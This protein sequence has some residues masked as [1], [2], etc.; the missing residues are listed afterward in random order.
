MGACAS[1]P[2]R[3]G[4]ASSS[5]EGGGEGP[6]T[7]P[8]RFGREGTSAIGRRDPSRVVA[9]SAGPEAAP[10][11]RPSRAGLAAELHARQMEYDAALARLTL[12]SAATKS[13]AAEFRRRSLSSGG[14]TTVL[15]QHTHMHR[16]GRSGSVP[17]AW[18]GGGDDG[19]GV[20]G[21][22]D[23]KE[24]NDR[25]V[26]A[27]SEGAGRSGKRDVCD[28]CCSSIFEGSPFAARGTIFAPKRGSTTTVVLACG[29]SYHDECF[30]RLV[31][32]PGPDP[33]C[34][35]CRPTEGH[36]HAHTIAV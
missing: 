31:P 23:E 9:G 14:L 22:E 25:G 18:V 27:S 13:P 20:H 33:C 29:C 19:A 8:E 11:S 26:W 21:P 24:L 12:A 2:L 17:V 28:H 5:S 7:R 32:N 6:S 4:K 16:L 1:G 3:Q 35:I 34:P 36:V 10:S 15:P 30:D